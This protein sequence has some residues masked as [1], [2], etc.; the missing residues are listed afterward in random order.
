MDSISI[1]QLPLFIL[2]TL[3]GLLSMK[4]YGLLMPGERPAGST[5]LLEAVVYGVANL[6]IWFFPLAFV[7]LPRRFDHPVQLVIAGIVMLFVSPIA[8]AFAVNA[9]LRWK[10]MRPWIRHPLPT[11][12][13]Y[14]F[15]RLPNGW[16]LIRLKSG[17]LIGGLIGANSF[18]SS[19]PHRR[20]LY[21]EQTWKL[22]EDGGFEAAVPQS[23]GVI[24]SMDD[25]ETLEF[26]AWDEGAEGLMETKNDD[27][28]TESK[29]SDAQANNKSS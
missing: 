28:G 17:L 20:D 18:A 12:W 16:V 25:C 11:A 24:V 2:L 4:V 21:V 29:Q 26:F 8:L 15:E 5:L 14:L 7:F 13:D 6:G 23:R 9:L 27:Q 3:P 22:N 1:Q 19:F 10:R